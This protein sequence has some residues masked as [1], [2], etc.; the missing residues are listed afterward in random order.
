MSGRPFVS[1]AIGEV[2]EYLEDGKTAF[3]S[4]SDSVTEFAAKIEEALIN[5]E[6]SDLIGQQG[7]NV[8]KEQF[9]YILRGEELLQ[10]LKSLGNDL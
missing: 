8:A 2:G 9:N 3:L 4:N 5:N 6:R 10:F 7:K 1:N